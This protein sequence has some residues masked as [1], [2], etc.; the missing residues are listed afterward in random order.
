ME[1]SNETKAKVFAQYLGQQVKLIVKMD[2][3]YFGYNEGIY[4]LAATILDRLNDLCECKLILKPLNKIIDEDVVEWSRQDGKPIGKNDSSYMFQSIEEA[5]R[6]LNF[7]SHPNIGWQSYQYL[8]SKGY[9][10][11]NYLLNGKTLHES[12]LAIYE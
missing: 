9:D 5:K 12:G 8:Q 3:N 1:I 2:S 6:Y 7:Y 10:L 11:P 4:T